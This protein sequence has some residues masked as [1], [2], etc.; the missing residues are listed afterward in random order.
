MPENLLEPS[1]I[2]L[3]GREVQD[4][5][6]A[7][8]NVPNPYAPPPNI[9][10]HPAALGDNAFLRRQLEAPGAR[11]ARIYGFSYEGHYYDLH[12]PAIFL[13]HGAGVLAQ[14]AATPFAK[15]AESTDRTGVSAV[16]YEYS[17]DMMVWSY[18]K[19]DF[20]IRLD[21]AGGTFEALLLEAELD[22]DSSHYSGAKVSGGKVGGGKV[23]DGKVGGGKVGGGKV[24]GRYRGD[25]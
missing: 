19:E 12:R 20:S 8:V 14:T 16:D 13:V 18:D 6:I 7:H 24:G 2:L 9:P 21:P 4:L 15:S 10:V 5:Q 11:L 25:E 17:G 1:N 23:G 3:Y 22:D